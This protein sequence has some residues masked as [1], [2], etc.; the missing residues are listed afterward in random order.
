MK[1]DIM[2]ITNIKEVQNKKISKEKSFNNNTSSF[3]KNFDNVLKKAEKQKDNPNKEVK[4]LNKEEIKDISKSSENDKAVDDLNSTHEKQSENELDDI[5]IETL[6]KLLLLAN[7]NPSEEKIAEIKIESTDFNKEITSI[8]NLAIKDTLNVLDSL[9]ASFENDENSTNL[10][11]SIKELFKNANDNIE[12]SEI[13]DFLGNIKVVIKAQDKSIDTKNDILDVNTSK[14]S[15]KDIK[16]ELVKL[17]NSKGISNEE[18]KTFNTKLENVDLKMINIFKND[19]TKIE[20]SQEN[21]TIMSDLEVVKQEISKTT[22]DFSQ[23]NNEFKDGEESSEDKVLSKILSTDEN[24]TSFDINIQRLRDFSPVENKNNIVTVNKSTMDLDIK[25]VIRNMNIN[26]NKELI[27]KV[28]PGNLGEIAIKL[29]SEG[30]QMK[31]L[32]KVSSKETF[33]LINSHEIKTLL[34]NDSIK[35][36]SVD[37]SLYED[38]TFFDEQSKFKEDEQRGKCKGNLKD[39]FIELEEEIQEISLSNLNII[40]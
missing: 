20:L 18:I 17:L 34:S 12:L 33:A 30:D 1:I 19:I 13:K 40:V 38:T 9:Y 26:N 21:T 3:E 25:N 4:V 15:L 6:I 29:V 7:Q 39:E 31:A 8:D 28:N 2:E 32:I 22:T 24:K 27:V 35:I 36:S 11:N 16:L 23:N 5:G 10:L 37:I 14:E